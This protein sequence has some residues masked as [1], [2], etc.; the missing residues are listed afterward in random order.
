[1][2]QR[3]TN[4]EASTSRATYAPGEE[5]FLQRQLREFHNPE[6]IDKVAH[7]RDKHGVASPSACAEWVKF[8]PLAG[9]MSG[10]RKA[11]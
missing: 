8:D 10:D 4:V 11:K 3:N 6:T 9:K 1:M 5:T 2:A 7:R